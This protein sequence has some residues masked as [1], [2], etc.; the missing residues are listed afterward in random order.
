MITIGRGKPVPLHRLLMEIKLGCPLLP[1]EDVHHLDG[2]KQNSQFENLALLSHGEHSHSSNIAY[3]WLLYCFH[4][5]RPFARHKHERHTPANFC[6]RACVAT[7]AICTRWHHHG[8]RPA[9]ARAPIIPLPTFLA[10]TSLF[11]NN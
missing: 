2:D 4:C 5:G 11:A 3:P 1:G 7:Y 10:A 8:K 6:S 9:P